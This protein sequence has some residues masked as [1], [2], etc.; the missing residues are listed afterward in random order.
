MVVCNMSDN[1][2]IFRVLNSVII[3]ENGVKKIVTTPSII[4]KSNDEIIKIYNERR[5]GNE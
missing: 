2:Q 1:I 3:V 4:E 5:C